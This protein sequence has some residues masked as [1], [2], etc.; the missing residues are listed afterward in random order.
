MEKQ[1]DIVGANGIGFPL[2]TGFP[3]LLSPCSTFVGDKI[4]IGDHL[5]TDKALL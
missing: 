1:D 3:C 5:S 4:V 2:N